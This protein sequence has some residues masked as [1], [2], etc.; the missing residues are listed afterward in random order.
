[1]ESSLYFKDTNP[2]A[3]ALSLEGISSGQLSQFT[4]NSF[5]SHTPRLEVVALKIVPSRS[6]GK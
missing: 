2:L 1:V 6:G 3:F 5:S 4:L